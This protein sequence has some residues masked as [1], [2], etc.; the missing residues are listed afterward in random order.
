MGESRVGGFLLCRRRSGAVAV[1]VGLAIAGGMWR[2]ERGV[3][4]VRTYI[5]GFYGLDLRRAC[6]VAEGLA[7][8]RRLPWRGTFLG[9][10]MRVHCRLH[11]RRIASEIFEL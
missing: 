5:C 6:C 2:R 10:I 1:T 4:A 8:Q 11:F 3:V 9:W 7:V